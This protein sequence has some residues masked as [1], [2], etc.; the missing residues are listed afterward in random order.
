MYVFLLII[1]ITFDVKNAILKQQQNN[2]WRPEITS[3]KRIM[4]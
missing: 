4:I 2:I 1:Y 3:K